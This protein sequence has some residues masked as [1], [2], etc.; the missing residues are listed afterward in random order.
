MEKLTPKEL[1]SK[2]RQIVKLHDKLYSRDSARDL[3][4]NARSIM[5]VFQRD[6]EHVKSWFEN[7]FVFYA[8]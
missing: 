6:K 5:T 8:K 4:K 7:K 1:E 3:R 2:R